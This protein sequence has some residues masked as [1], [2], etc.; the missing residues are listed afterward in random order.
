M[1]TYDETR[2]L[3]GTDVRV[4]LDGAGVDAAGRAFA[5]VEEADR[6]LS[7]FRPD[8]DLSRLNADPRAIVPAGTML[9]AL[10][11]AAR[12]AAALTGGLAD[13]TLGAEI[14]RIGYESSRDEWTEHLA[15][16]LAAAPPR[17]PARP[18]ARWREV[19]VLPGAVSRPPGLQLDSGGVGKGLAAGLALAAAA[20]APRALVDCGGDIAARGTWEIGVAHPLTGDAVHAF[21]ID[22]GAV[23]T[24]AIHRRLWRRPGGGFAHH[25]LDPSTGE[26]AWTGVLQAT[27]LAPTPVHAEALAKAALLAGP[28]G[29]ERILSAYGGL[30]FLE[31]G[32]SR[33][34]V[35]RAGRC[36]A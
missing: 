14:A 24:S 29:A 28:A 22:G 23:A 25:L 36:A 35:A 12:E 19:R 5:V 21:R 8:S 33:L 1:T 6:T 18:T 4:V 34:V 11:A 9:R 2:R 13:A 3:M 15:E 16:A 20:Q 17:R 7:R 10:V 26:P 31:E 27:A 32:A 30:L